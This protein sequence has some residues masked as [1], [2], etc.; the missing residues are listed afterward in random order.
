MHRDRVVHWRCL[1]LSHAPWPWCSLTLSSIITCTVTVLFT[2][3]VWHYHMHRDRGV[4]W[5]CLALSQGGHKIWKDIAPHFVN[6]RTFP[7]YTLSCSRLICRLQNATHTSCYLYRVSVSILLYYNN[8]IYAIPGIM[9][10]HSARQF[11]SVLMSWKVK[12]KVRKVQF[13]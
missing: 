3:A 7:Q 8:Y 12:I 5:R 2:D 6:D 1:A 10:L 13:L 9:I 4:H 11:M